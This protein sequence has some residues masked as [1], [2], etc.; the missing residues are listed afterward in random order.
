MH[1][2]KNGAVYLIKLLNAIIIIVIMIFV[3]YRLIESRDSSAGTTERNA[4]QR[5][6]LAG[7]KVIPTKKQNAAWR[8]IIYSD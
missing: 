2:Q 5:G 3:S 7:I 8:I 4:S 6:P 1:T